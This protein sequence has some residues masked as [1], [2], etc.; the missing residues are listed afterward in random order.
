MDCDGVCNNDADGDGV[1][2]EL[3]I[4]GCTNPAA[5]SHH[6]PQTTMA[7]VLLRSVDVRCRLRNFDPT[8]DFYLPGSCD[9]SCLFGM[10]PG[11]GN[12]ADELAC[13]FGSDEP[14]V[15]FDSEGNICAEVG[16]T[17]ESACNFLDAQINGACE[18]DSCQV[19]GCTNA[20]ACNYNANAN[21][22][23][24]SCD[25]SS[26][27]GCTNSDASITT[28]MRLWTMDSACLTCQDVRS[29]PL[30]TTIHRRL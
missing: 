4:P 14:C 10:P 16:C 18:F 13:N 17:N 27:V 1:C 25:Y 12:C 8:A 29:L 30:A 28:Q 6:L 9:F 7:P 3:E 26:C 15:Y 20:N 19:F 11:D 2:D 5:S 24:G 23:N 22:E 21:T